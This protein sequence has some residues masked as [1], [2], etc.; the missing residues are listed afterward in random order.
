MCKQPVGAIF[1]IAHVRCT[2]MA[3]FAA[4]YCI[5]YEWSK[6]IQFPMEYT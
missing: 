3:V 1:V 4:N 5:I 6:R 2:V